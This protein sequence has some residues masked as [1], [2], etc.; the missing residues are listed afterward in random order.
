MPYLGGVA[1]PPAQAGEG[2]M[3]ASTKL[4]WRNSR[5]IRGVRSQLQ[6]ALNACTNGSTIELD[7]T[8]ARNLI[9][10]CLQAEHTEE[11]HGV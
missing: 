10:V 2:L 11:G 8:S 1:D 9:E 6:A 4:V 5:Q 7:T 3:K